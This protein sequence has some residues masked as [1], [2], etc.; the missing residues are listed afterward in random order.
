MRN[1]LCESGCWHYIR[2]YRTYKNNTT[3]VCIAALETVANRAVTTME[4]KFF[5][6]F[7]STDKTEK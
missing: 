1:N 4:T 6:F 7:P 5:F 2:I 3:E